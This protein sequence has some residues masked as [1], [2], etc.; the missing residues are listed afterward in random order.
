MA[1]SPANDEGG[2]VEKEGGTE[3]GKPAHSLPGQSDVKPRKLTIHAVSIFVKNRK[4][5]YVNSAKVFFNELSLANSPP[6]R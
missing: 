3:N 5:L 6:I 1:V 4:N 2:K